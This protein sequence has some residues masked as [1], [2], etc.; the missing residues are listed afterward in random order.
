MH[1][2][3]AFL[4]QPGGAL[5]NRVRNLGFGDH[6]L[7]RARPV[8]D[9]QKRHLATGPTVGHPTHEGDLLAI[10]TGDVSNIDAW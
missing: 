6:R 2:K 10:E 9:N 3:R 8:A 7:N 1:D 5:P 4:S